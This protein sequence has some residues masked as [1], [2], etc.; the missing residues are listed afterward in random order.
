M[1]VISCLF[2]L[3]ISIVFICTPVE[4]VKSYLFKTCEQSGFCSRNR[5]LAGEIAKAGGEYQPRYSVNIESI[6]AHDNGTVSGLIEKSLN[7]GS[8]V[9]LPFTISV[10]ED[11]NLRLTIDEARRLVGGLGVS[12]GK[13]KTRRY[14]EAADWALQDGKPR[15]AEKGAVEVKTSSDSLQLKYGEYETSVQY[16]PFKVAVKYKGE[17]QLILNHDNL[18]NIEHFRTKEEQTAEDSIHVSPEESTFDSFQDSFKDSKKDKL[19]FGPESVSVDVSFVGYDHVYGIPEHA[20]SLEL[21][22]TV[23]AEPY[24]LY[25]VDIFEYE[26]NSRLPMY[27]AIPFMFGVK[28]GFASGVFWMNSA[29]TYVDIE[30]V[31]HGESTLT[32]EKRTTSHWMSESGVLDVVFFV[33]E[34][35]QE[36]STS[37]GS[38]TGFVQLPNLFSLGYHQCRWNYNDESDVLQVHNN[39]DKY[40]IP[41]DTIWLDIEY[42]EEKK[43]FTWK[44]ELFPDP[45][46]MLSVLDET[47][48]YMV[49]IIDP[50]LKVN[51]E[52]SDYVVKHSLGVRDSDCKKTYHGHCW[53]G[54]SVW[55]DTL[56]PEA[57]QYW[58]E[59]YVNGSRLMG[60][61]QNLHIWNDMNEP[62]VFNGPETSAPKDLVHFQNWEHRSVHNL[63]GMTFHEATYDALKTRF[64]NQR[65]FILTRSFFSGSQ[66]T[67]AMWT[68]DNMAKWEYLRGSIPMVLTLNVVGMPFAGADV[69]GFFGDPS[70]ELLVRWYQ[71]GI[72][73]PFFRAHAHIDSRRREPWIAGEPYTS[74]MRDAVR[75]RYALLPVFY[76]AFQESHTVGTPVMRP[77][78]YETPNNVA[79]YGIED[80][81]FVGNSGLLVKPVVDEGATSVDVYLPDDELYYDFQTFIALHGQGFH[82]VE[83]PL[84]KIPV[85]IKGGHVVAMKQR[86][87]RSS[88]LMKY[89]PYTLVIALSSKGSASGKLY[90]DD[91]ETFDN[92]LGDFVN[93]AFTFD[94]RKL[95]SSVT[96]GLDQPFVQSLARVTVERIIF[97]GDLKPSK[98]IKVSQGGEQWVAQYESSEGAITIKNPQVKINSDWTVSV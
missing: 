30:R 14:N 76:T 35:P 92:E 27:G 65:P 49:V 42:T 20:D 81:F 50:H 17:T 18:L 89:D 87:R 66:R 73:Y 52:V 94:G 84:E 32:T 23:G 75:L 69:G 70:K 96:G 82:T 28:P 95:S 33:K 93:V 79:S 26:I 44:K 10:L 36:L 3:W 54:E 4:G 61:S 29:D 47:G 37:Y 68:G 22:D 97:I 39:M 45:D 63:Y 88:K 64:Y 90:I 8:V 83:A 56:D 74:I 43:Y 31:K 13:L 9:G 60:N 59:L 40:G 7:D 80:E 91:G 62:S 57:S 53:P 38:L 12:N 25:N 55:I 48:R 78:F 5:H 1:R 19:P 11:S 86:Y 98:E 24:R 16:Y 2:S 72:W 71:T 77:V 46:R 85:F 67:A 34:S 21:K 6:L 15:I 41:Y 58:S 51:Y